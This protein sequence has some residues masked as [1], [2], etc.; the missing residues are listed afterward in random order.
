MSHEMDPEKESVP[1]PPSTEVGS[2]EEP[3]R[4]SPL[5]AGFSICLK[6]MRFCPHALSFGHQ[7]L[8][9]HPE[10]ASFAAP[11]KALKE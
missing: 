5:V 2:D 1:A 10:H 7:Y 9:R 4:T 11:K 6:K 8:C 3:C